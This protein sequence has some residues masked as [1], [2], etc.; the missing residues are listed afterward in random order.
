MTEWISQAHGS[1][2]IGCSEA[3]V[4]YHG[5]AMD[6]P[7]GGGHPDVAGGLFVHERCECFQQRA[8]FSV[9]RREVVDKSSIRKL[10]HL[11]QDVHGMV[12]GPPPRTAEDCKDE[13]P[14]RGPLAQLAE[15]WTFN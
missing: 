11:V 3:T 4:E 9:V 2:L 14:C 7:S 10:G 1:E 12:H 15:Q 5:D 13:Q 8:H 6:G